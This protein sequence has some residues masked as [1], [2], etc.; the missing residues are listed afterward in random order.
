LA[1]LHSPEAALKVEKSIWLY[2]I[3]AIEAVLAP[4]AVYLR[5]IRLKMSSV[6][7]LLNARIIKA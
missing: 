7:R 6:P 2:L 1:P 3:Y 4:N 5:W